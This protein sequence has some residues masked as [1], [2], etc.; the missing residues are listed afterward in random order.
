MTVYVD[1]AKNRYGRM[2]MCHMLADTEAELH[3]MAD[4]IGVSRHWFQ[5]HG[6]P[7]YDLCQTK[8]TLALQYGAVEIGR[9]EVVALARRLRA[10]RAP[11]EEWLEIPAFL[12]RDAG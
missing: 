2:L 12:R 3:S 6:T 8:R 1:S 9:R 5:G 4:R 7:H 11:E 10:A